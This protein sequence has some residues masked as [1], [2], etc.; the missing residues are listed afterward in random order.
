MLGATC[1]TLGLVVVVGYVN[2]SCLDDYELHCLTKA[3]V[4]QHLVA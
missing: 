2:S 4:I 3:L 1:K